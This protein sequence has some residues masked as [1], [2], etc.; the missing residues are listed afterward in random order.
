MTL[1]MGI[2]FAAVV[3]AGYL[4]APVM[5]VWGWIRY[6][7]RID[8]PEH[9]FFLAF[10]GFLLSTASAFLAIAAVAYA[11]MHGFAYYD[12]LLLRVFRWGG[13]LSLGGLVLGSTGIARPNPLRWQAPLAGI[14]MLAFWIISAAGE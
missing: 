9:P 4:L 5:L 1:G 10:I 8:K 13:L 7:R 12:P 2:L 3:A 11:I 14:G 6:L